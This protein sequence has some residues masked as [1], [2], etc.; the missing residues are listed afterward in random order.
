MDDLRYVNKFTQMVDVNDVSQEDSERY[1]RYVE[2]KKLKKKK[3]IPDAPVI[4]FTPGAAKVASGPSNAGISRPPPRRNDAPSSNSR[5]SLALPNQNESMQGSS[6]RAKYK[7]TTE[8]TFSV[9]IDSRDRDVTIYP[10]ASS[11]EVYLRKPFHNVHK[12]TLASTELPNTDDVIKDTPAEAR[13]NII[14]WVNSEDADI[15][16]PVYTAYVRRGTYSAITLQNEMSERMNTVKTRAGAGGFHSFIVKID[17]DTSVVTFTR[18]TNRQ[19]PFNG[20]S[21]TAGSNLIQAT[22][23]SHGFEVGDAVYV[24]GVRGMVGSITASILNSNFTVSNVI[25]D[26]HFEFEVSSTASVTGDGG[27]TSTN[28]GRTVPFKL[29]FGRSQGTIGNIIGFPEEDSSTPINQENPLTPYVL[30]ITDVQIGYPT[31]I[32]SPNHGLVQGML[33]RIRGLDMLPSMT[34]DVPFA[35][36]SVPDTNTFVL[37]I[38]TTEIQADS[39]PNALIYT[40]RITLHFP[41]HGFNHVVSI[42]DSPI[43]FGAVRVV[44]LLP[45]GL[46]TGSSVVLNNTNSVPSLNGQRAVTRI[47]DDTFE[48]WIDED[49][50]SGSP[51][52]IFEGDEGI[53][54]HSHNFLLYNATDVGSIVARNINDRALRVD[55]ILDEDNFTFRLDGV[56]PTSAISGGGN[57]ISISS[58]AHGFLGIQ[59]NTDADN[60]LVRPISL[61]GENYVFLCINQ[62]GNYVNTGSVDDI[63]A[64]IL[65]NKPPGEV[66]FNSFVPGPG[67]VFYEGALPELSKLNVSIRTHANTLFEFN[68]VDFSFTIEITEFV[69]TFIDDDAD[70]TDIAK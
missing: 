28:I 51:P 31:I 18:L 45:H 61:A 46:I 63:F 42:S 40:E 47:S 58:D 13:N 7:K 62:L 27:G 49:V 14:A 67:V 64:K 26:D 15:G 54:G 52:L 4:G 25:D 8:R 68:G 6:L 60:N 65:L 17:R 38:R 30:T 50:M 56:V 1:K 2:A 5:R 10:K 48:V 34:D 41:G 20:F 44:T 12:V 35:V 37:N 29:L 59:N 9:N 16:F 11:F 57:F 66:L 36:Y 33:V 21:F 53:L 69:D 32:T 55:T 70:V 43:Q 3:S 19:L 22:L 24:S 23:L 39:I